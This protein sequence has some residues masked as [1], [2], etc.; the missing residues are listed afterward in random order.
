MVLAEVRNTRAEILEAA[1]DLFSTSG[2]EGTSLREVAERLEFTKAALYYHFR[3]K[4]ELAA[5]VLAPLFLAVDELL[6]SHYEMKSSAANVRAVLSAYADII[7]THAR[8]VRFAFSDLAVL[9]HAGLG[10]RA[11]EQGG[12]LVALLTTPE[13]SLRD[14]TKAAVA[15]AGLQIAVSSL[16]DRDN[17]V[18]KDAAVEAAAGALG[19]RPSSKR[20]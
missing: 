5:E 4:E 14:T 17:T 6:E 20:A 19:Y 3:T 9:Q 15:I 7:L 10:P 12:R 2:Y 8:L 16:S 11:M 13:P 18:V 1:L